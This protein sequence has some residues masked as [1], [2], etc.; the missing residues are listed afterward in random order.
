MDIIKWKKVIKGYFIKNQATLYI[1]IGFWLSAHSLFEH[2]I[3]H[4]DC[5][6]SSVQSRCER[7]KYFPIA[8]LIFVLF[9]LY[10]K[11]FKKPKTNKNDEYED[12]HKKD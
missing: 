9:I 2:F 7:G 8:Y 12:E 1:V 10:Q 5:S 6:L 3:S 4:R 11:Y